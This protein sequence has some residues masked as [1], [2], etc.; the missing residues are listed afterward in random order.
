[1]VE[2]LD[3]LAMSCEQLAAEAVDAGHLELAADAW[4]TAAHL[5][6]SADELWAPVAAHG[7]G[8]GPD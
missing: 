1:M 5:L 4:A 2:R 6:G 7:D 3:A 8:P